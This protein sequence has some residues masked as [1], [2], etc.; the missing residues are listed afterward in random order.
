MYFI[1]CGIVCLLSAR[2]SFFCGELGGKGACV[3]KI[4]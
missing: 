1:I 2:I 4:S 3:C